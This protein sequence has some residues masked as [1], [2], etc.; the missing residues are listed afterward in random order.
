MQVQVSFG[1]ALDKLSILEIKH[2]LI[3]NPQ[4]QLEVQKEIAAL[5]Q[6][7]ECREQ[8]K[9]VE[10]LYGM[11]KFINRLIWDLTNI[12]KGMNVDDPRFS[13]VSLQIFDHNQYRFRVKNMINHTLCSKKQI[14]GIK[15]QK[16]YAQT[17]IRFVIDEFLFFRN[18]FKVFQASCLYDRVILMVNK[19]HVNATFLENVVSLLDTPNFMITEIDQ[20]GP[21]G[22]NLAMWSQ[23]VFA[24]EHQHYFVPEFKPI[25][26]VNGGL[27]GDFIHS[28]GVCSVIFWQ[29]GRKAIVYIS[30]RHGDPFA[31]GVQEAY[32][33]TKDLLECQPYIEKYG[34]HDN[35]PVD[36]DLSCWRRRADLLYRTTWNQIYDRS[37]NISGWGKYP[38]LEVKAPESLITKYANTV[39]FNCSKLRMSCLS[40]V[41]VG[42]LLQN[43][44]DIQYLCMK[45]TDAQNFMTTNNVS[46]SWVEAKT[47]LEFCQIICGSKGFI[48][49]LSSPLAFVIALNKRCIGLIGNAGVDTIHMKELP[50]CDY[51]WYETA[52]NCAQT[53]EAFLGK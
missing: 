26:Y 27:L 38:W 52:N 45:S 44:H 8:Y 9:T 20:C 32:E 23:D 30:I 22:L 7:Q 24:T 5:N 31:F 50:I 28:L 13:T 18:I 16:S 6:A 15:E 3:S 34:I 12:V 14:D 42:L 19:T 53:V 25:T 41:N 21:E 29:T 4:Q 2:E 51:H 1:E 33:F 35:Q 11:L 36:I 37:Y 40:D 46:M 39:F 49:N 43:N 48:G 47:A 10:F 17:E